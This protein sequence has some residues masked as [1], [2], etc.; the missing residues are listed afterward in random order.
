[1]LTFRRT[2]ICLAAALIR[3]LD[4]PRI[5]TGLQHIVDNWKEPDRN[6]AYTFEWSDDFS[7]GVVP[8]NCHSHNDYWRS[9]PMYEA[10]AAGCVG[11]E[12][13]IWLMEDGELRVSHSWGS[14]HAYRTLRSLYLDPLSNIFTNRNVSV[15]ST[16]ERNVG[17]FDVDPNVS[18]VLLIDFKNDGH[19]IWPVLMKQLQ[20]LREKGW[21]THF[22]G[23]RVVQGPLTIVGT[24]DVPFELVQG[25]DADRF[26]FFDAPL[27]DISNSEYTSENSYYA[28]I[29]MRK[30]VGR[31]LFNRLS[32]RQVNIL[33]S[34]I[35][36]A[37]DKGLVSRYWSTPSWPI[38]LRQKV[39]FTL[40]ENNVGVLNVDDLYSA[41]RW[42]WNWCVIAG[43]T[44]CGS[45]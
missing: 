27:N 30:A 9:V 44:L 25:M 17:I 7:R 35:R 32:A 23:T 19:M 11:I 22:D 34:Q 21:L 37:S 26:V 29:A 15:A 13:D 10:F 42:N 40:V 36:A 28:S 16:N 38:S 4:P 3:R 20:P 43:L 33:R 5:N 12:A 14:I 18:V 2:Y 6:G 31:I 8:K 45:G 39:W 41:T 1:M 24:G